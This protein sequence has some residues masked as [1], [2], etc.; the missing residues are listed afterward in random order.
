DY[1]MRE[2]RGHWSITLRNE[3]HSSLDKVTNYS[4]LYPSTIQRP[5]PA[6]DEGMMRSLEL[7]YVLGGDRTPFAIIGQNRVEIKAEWSNSDIFNSDFN[8]GS[9]QIAIDRRIPTFY[10]RR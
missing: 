2:S 10:K 9:Y 8:Y 3:E 1:R 6:I 7:G 5:N 4:L